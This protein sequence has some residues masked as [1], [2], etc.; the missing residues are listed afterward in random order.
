MNARGPQPSQRSR[1]AQRERNWYYRRSG[2]FFNQLW[3]F[4]EKACILKPFWYYVDSEERRKE[5]GHEEVHARISHRLGRENQ[6]GVQGSRNQ[7]SSV[8]GS[9][10]LQATLRFCR[11][12]DLSKRQ[13][14]SCVDS[15][16]GVYNKPRTCYNLPTR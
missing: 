5:R 12:L 10:L 8:D 15:V 13:R 2:R 6:A 1:W 7:H 16:C 3:R 11:A 14:I 4:C 9:Q